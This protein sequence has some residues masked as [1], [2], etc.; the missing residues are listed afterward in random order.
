MG[1]N[2]SKEPVFHANHVDDSVHVMLKHSAKE[3]GPHCYVPRAAHPL[4]NKKSCQNTVTSEEDCDDINEVLRLEA[5][6][7]QQSRHSNVSAS[8]GDEH[9]LLHYAKFHNDLIDPRDR[10]V[11]AFDAQPLAAKG[12]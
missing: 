2:N 12:C 10:V 4:L 1:C 9:R 3:P 8:T 11:Q 7:S 5:E 6:E